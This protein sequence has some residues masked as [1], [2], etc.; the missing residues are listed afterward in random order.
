M[1][2]SCFIIS[3]IFLI[4]LNLQAK[5]FTSLEQFQDHLKRESQKVMDSEKHAKIKSEREVRDYNVG[6]SRNFWRWDLSVMPPT[7]E[8]SQATCRAVGEDCY[9]FVS[10]DQWNVNMD[11]AV[12]D[13]VMNYLE[14][15]TMAGDDFGAIQ[16]DEDLF[17]PIP[18]ELD[19]D[20]KIIVYYSALGMFN[21]TAF[22]GYFSA[23]NQVTEQEAQQMNPPGHSN[24]C[25]MIYMTCHP[26]DPTDPV[27]ISVLSHELQHMIHWLGDISEDTWVDEGM[28]ELAMVHFGMPDPIS[29]FNTN[30][31]LSLNTWDQ[32]WADYV[33]VLLFFTYFDEHFES[34][35]LIKDIVAE[36]QNGIAGISNQL[37]EHGFA[38]PFEAIFNYWSVANYLDE[39]G[40]Y[41]GVYN[42]Q[43]L[44]LPIFSHS[45][46]HNDFPVA[47]SGTVNPWATKYVVV[48]HSNE[49]SL[50]FNVNN[51]IGLGIIKMGNNI[52][53]EVEILPV[54][55]NETVTLPA[56]EA[57]YTNHVL[58]IANAHDQIL[59]FSYEI[60]NA[61]STDGV[62]INSNISLR[63]YP[64]PFSLSDITSSSS[65]NGN[66][67]GTTISFSL[68]ESYFNS[69]RTNSQI[70]IEIYNF[71][72]QNVKSIAISNYQIGNNNV[73]WNGKNNKGL[74]VSS[75]IYLYK[76]VT[77][78]REVTNKMLLIK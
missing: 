32:L 10:D 52:N 1:K 27:R 12:V 29:S 33:K 40:I 56:L 49:L 70:K 34:E 14:N 30:P 2:R 47:Q 61:V 11:Q 68:P 3:I 54:N 48:S 26:L 20:P 13:T 77:P 39:E 15:T 69:I 65:Y 35:D 55:M 7:W 37:I 21:G 19:N 45:Y 24:E 62:T 23:Y 18:D 78:D 73:I 9:V 67:S 42:Y 75:G 50:N 4:V 6:D 5:E 16:M 64:N 31:N 66:I 43:A 17:G 36:P 51:N 57:P 8:Q 71:K 41:D 22:D 44:E 60:D 25:E 74:P 28:A 38:I 59:N 53:S 72:G 63:N 76:L 58:T 46:F